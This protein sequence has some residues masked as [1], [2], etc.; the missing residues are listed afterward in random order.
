MKLSMFK[1]GKSTDLLEIKKVRI[2][3]QMPNLLM[4]YKICLICDRQFFSEDRRNQHT[5]ALCRENPERK[6]AR[7]L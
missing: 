1:E 4:G 6:I 7:D 5:C 2:A 3:T